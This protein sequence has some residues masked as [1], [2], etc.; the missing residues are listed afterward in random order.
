M[1]GDDALTIRA[2]SSGRM[3]RDDPD[4]WQAMLTREGCPWCQ[5][6]GPPPE[7]VLAETDTCW[8]TGGPVALILGYAC[9]ST[10]AH[11]VE[12]YDLDGATQAAFWADAMAVARGLASPTEPF[13]VNLC[14]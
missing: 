12:P 5:G 11:A 6:P 1:D 3:W 14:R 7:D 8:V 2:N 10:K 4:G 9:V 13:D